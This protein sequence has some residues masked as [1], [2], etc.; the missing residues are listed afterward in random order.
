M[1]LQVLHGE[2][3]LELVTPMTT[4]GSLTTKA[5]VLDVQQKKSG[6]VITAECK[7]FI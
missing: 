7:M 6:V 4:E 1:T 5:S 2:Q 3:F